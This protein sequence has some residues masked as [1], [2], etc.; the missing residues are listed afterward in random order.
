M[1]DIF[2]DFICKFS[3]WLLKCGL[4][5]QHLSRLHSHTFPREHFDS[6]QKSVFVGA[7]GANQKSSAYTTLPQIA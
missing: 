3:K 4:E 7:V 2:E 1:A 6:I 5:S